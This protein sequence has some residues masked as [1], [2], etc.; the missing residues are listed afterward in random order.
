M[1]CSELA[2]KLT[3]FIDGSLDP[4]EEAAAIEHLAT[5]GE[6][7]AVLAGTRSVVALASEHAKVDLSSDERTRVLS[8]VLAAAGQD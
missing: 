7:E 4:A 5:C 2:A 3:D 1:Q 8:K 6:C